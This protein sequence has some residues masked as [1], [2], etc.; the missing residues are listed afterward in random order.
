MSYLDVIKVIKDVKDPKD[1]KDP[2]RYAIR[3]Y[4]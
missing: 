3:I 2:I 4:L 1:L